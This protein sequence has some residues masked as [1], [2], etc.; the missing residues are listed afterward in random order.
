MSTSGNTRYIGRPL[1]RLGDDRLITGTAA[2]LDDIRVPGLLHL[3][4]VRSPLAHALIR[5]VDSATALALPGVV[6]VVTGREL[7]SWVSPLSSPPELLSGRRLERYPLAVDRARFVGDPVAAVLAVDPVAAHEAAELV[8]V[9]YGELPAVV[10]AER[11]REATAP[12]VYPDWPDNVAFRWE[13]RQGD[14]EAMFRQAD[15]TVSLR[16]VNQRIYAA[17][18]EPR[19]A[20]AR[21]DRATG[22]LTVWASTQAPHGLRSGLATAVGLP[23]HQIRVIVPEVGGAFGS[24]GGVYPEYVLVAAL[25][26]QLGR[27]V[28]WVET[29]SE[30][31]LGTVHARDQVQRVRAAFRRDG[32]LLGLDVQ[33][34]A[35]LGAYNAAT[36][37][38]RT[39]LLAAG[40]YRVPAL[41]VLVE[42]IMTNCAPL[43]SYRGA[44]R[45][46]AAYLLERLMD[47][48]AAE[49]DLDPAEIRRRNLLRADEFPYRSP[50]GA[51]YDSGDYHRALDIALDR[52]GYVEARAAQQR[53]RAEG[54]ILGIGLA[55]YCEF[56]GPG[57][58]SATVRVHPD[59][60]VSVFS[61]ITPSGQGHSTVLAQIV[62]DVLGV[63]LE[64]VRVRTGDTGA[65][66]QGIGTFG[67]RST[68]VGGSAAFLAAQDVLAKARQLAAHALEAS[69][70]DIEL[71]NG[72]FQVRG[73]PDRRVTWQSVARLAH[74]FDGPPGGLEPGLEATRF[75]APETRT[76]PS[77]VHI[78]MIEVD[79]ETGEIEVLR[80]LAVDDC[81]NQVNPLLVEGQIHGAVAQGIG[82]ALLE[83]VPYSESGQPLARSFLDYAV[84]RAAHVPDVETAHI[85]TPSP[86]N[87]LGAKGVGEA[88]TTAAPPAIV[89]AVLDALR[90]LGV[91]HLDMPLIPE[92]VWR[93]IR[94]ARSAPASA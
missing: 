69:P 88:G 86:L 73:A 8:T 24:K 49:L 74:R 81:G 64:R 58:E 34:L 39:G 84:P 75:F 5:D 68:A 78:A 11:A 20:L 72:A 55:C 70:D 13:V 9:S 53:A 28:K 22:E 71:Q 89:N 90:P 12:L 51:Q 40:P 48:A 59:G 85:E 43:G 94:E 38:L 66:Q 37:A 80:Y 35:N 26:W 61:G 76:V 41:H 30:S 32:T 2:F 87:P 83:W 4:L 56:A 44:G 92:R 31:L 47:A 63:D 57:W 19:G 7:A 15:V 25:A 6:A 27:P 77:G 50:T 21:P 23:E 46:E 10:D 3:A 54:R 14:L 65:I 60:A 82:Q 52:F 93:A 36:T 29:R 18:L 79:P 62:A 16:L 42:G 17:F 91:R 33:L 45:P 1:R 67:S